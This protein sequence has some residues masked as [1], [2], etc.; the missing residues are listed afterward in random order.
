[1]E[2]RRLPI[3]PTRTTKRDAALPLLRGLDLDSDDIKWL[4][5]GVTRLH[6]AWVALTWLLILLGFAVIALRASLHR[7]S[8]LSP[9]AAAIIAIISANIT[10]QSKETSSHSTET[11]TEQ[12][13]SRK[14]PDSSCPG[15]PSMRREVIQI[16]ENGLLE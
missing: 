15:N 3:P 1:M 10:T 8:P 11:A 4:L 16:I 5:E 6:F 2:C 13:A 14:R 7:A 9:V 12:P